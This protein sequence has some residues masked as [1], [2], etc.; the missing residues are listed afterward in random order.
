MLTHGG[1][2][3][4]VWHRDT[5]SWNAHL[6]KLSTYFLRYVFPIDFIWGLLPLS[7]I[8]Q[9]GHRILIP[10]NLSTKCCPYHSISEEHEITCLLTSYSE[11]MALVCYRSMAE[12]EVHLLLRDVQIIYSISCLSN[13]TYWW[14]S[15]VPEN[16]ICLDGKKHLKPSV[17][18][19]GYKM[20]R[21]CA[22]I[23]SPSRK[24]TNMIANTG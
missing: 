11:S 13:M 8:D 19:Q 20:G 21:A 14:K 12:K 15:A 5:V 7:L 16:I 4:Y 24:T 17:G 2:N 10:A 23:S 22:S 1:H 9:M 3:A 6:Q 18:A